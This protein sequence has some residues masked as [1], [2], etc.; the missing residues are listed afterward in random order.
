MCFPSSSSLKNLQLLYLSSCVELSSK[1]TMGI[2]KTTST[3]SPLCLTLDK[4]FGI[5]SPPENNGSLV[6]DLMTTV[7]PNIGDLPG[8]YAHNDT[9][10][11]T[12]SDFSVAHNNHHGT[13][14]EV[15]FVI[16]RIFTPLFCGFGI[17]GNILNILVLTR[18]RMQ[19]GSD[20][21]SERAAFMGLIALAVSDLCYCTSAF[22]KLF[23]PT[24]ATIFRSGDPKL[25][26]FLYESYILNSFSKIST[27]LTVI[28]AVSRFVAICHPLHA[29]LFVHFKGTVVAISMTFLLWFL[30]ELPECW[31]H[32]LITEVCPQES[33]IFLEL[34][35]FVN[36]T[37]L[38]LAF[39]Y[40]WFILGFV[41]PVCILAFCNIQLIR[42]LR[43][44][45]RMRQ[46]CRVHGG[47]QQP[48]SRITP[49]LIAIVL[50]FIF[51]MTPSEIINFTIDVLHMESKYEALIL[52]IT[53]LMNTINFSVNFV[54]YCV[55]NVH[56]RSTLV[57]LLSCCRK[58]DSRRKYA[59]SSYSAITSNTNL[60]TEE[61]I[62]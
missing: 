60:N 15:T 17:V 25:F 57:N 52:V 20:S 18:R 46:E 59:A 49:T 11:N 23:Y 22:P 2:T 19:S 61:N 43:A 35:V 3:A 39:Q 32:Q 7:M 21:G 62:M 29:R 5:S 41:V 36:N 34:G 53:N 38:R 4:A 12:T 30:L 48:G 24:K 54:L 51:L 33:Y 55:V 10:D 56:F 26:Y 14:D 16:S 37:K 27:W 28:M 45:A 6:Y 1:V 47:R 13:I 44:S 31:T 58:A 40:L 42:A 9:L 50:M 8:S